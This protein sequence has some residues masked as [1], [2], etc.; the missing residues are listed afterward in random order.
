MRLRRLVFIFHLSFFGFQ[1]AF[2]RSVTFPVHGLDVVGEEPVPISCEWDEKWFWETK[3]TTYH[4][5]IARIAALFSEISYVPVEKNPDSNELIRSYRL[6]GFKDSAIE[7][8]YMLD[9]TTPLRGNN[10][11]AYS[12]A[13]KDIQTPDGT[14]KL[15]FVVLR[16]TPLSANEWISNINVSDTTHKDT[17]VHEGFYNTMTNVHK[18]LIYYLLK[19]KISPDE[20]YFLITGHSRGAALAN[21]LGATLEDE[22]I[23]TG[24]RLFV[25]TFAAPNV[26]QAENTNDPKYDFI[27]NIVNAEDIVPSVPPARHNWKWKKFGQMRVIANYWNTDPSLYMNEYLPRM[28]EYFSKMLARDYA[29]FKNGPFIQIQIA[30]VLTNLY[31]TVEA[32]YGSMFGLRDM[33][34]DIFWKVFPEDEDG[35]KALK[36]LGDGSEKDVRE[37]KILLHLQKSINETT[38]NGFDYLKNA[39][40]DMHACESYLSWLLAFDENEVYS[41]LGSSQIVISGSYECAVYD[42]EGTLL[43]RIRDGILE[44]KSIK[45]PV[46]AFPLP[47]KVIIGFPGNQNLNVVI[48]KDSLIPTVISYEI[49]HYDAAGRLLGESEK[50]HL[51]PQTR[52]VISFKAG[53]VT[54][55][56]DEIDYQTLKG[57]DAGSLISEYDLRQNI[58][59]NVQLELGFTS[60]SIFTAGIRTGSQALFG[61]ILNSFSTKNAGKAF[62]L[63]LGIGHQ[64]SLFGRV[65]LDLEGFNKL[66]WSSDDVEGREFNVVPM[67][68]FTLSFKPRHRFHFFAGGT[69][70]LHVEDFNDGA[71]D[72]LNRDTNLH[73]LQLGDKTEIIPSFVFGIRM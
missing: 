18:A 55:E 26:T 17:I 40:L 52:R 68:R 38:T 63:L 15:V 37:S 46:S 48:H 6:L 33:A 19:Q 69:F 5:G 11:A 71:F 13:S 66:V 36:S 50:H 73:G 62:G 32:Y 72:M 7:H 28:N 9:Y 21:L 44:I 51:F 10:Q 24:E 14:K 49:E 70:E 1:F 2:A 59:F 23:I 65:L 34:E 29:P 60:D 30:R 3:T 12:F 20:A 45:I 27:W 8:N 35:E 54:L 22:G 43:A 67:G 41:S 64:Q 25:Y 61:T 57:K 53:D 39:F 16:G 42:N 31:K 58:K 47:N 4:H 56:S